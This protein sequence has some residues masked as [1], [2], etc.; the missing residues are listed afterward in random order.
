MPCLYGRLY[1]M[2]SADVVNAIQNAATHAKI[3]RH[4]I[5][6]LVLYVYNDKNMMVIKK[7]ETY[8]HYNY[9]HNYSYIMY[10]SSNYFMG[11]L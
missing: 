7:N 2:S 1:L 3:F 5:E 6:F 10:V 8:I 11:L 4:M 9:I